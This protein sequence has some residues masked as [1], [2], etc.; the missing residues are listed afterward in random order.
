[1][2]RSSYGDEMGADRAGAGSAVGGQASSRKFWAEHFAAQ[3]A[4]SNL[5]LDATQTGVVS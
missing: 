5:A 4:E 1:M 3:S 2:A